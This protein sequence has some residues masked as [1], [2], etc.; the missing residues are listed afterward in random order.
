MKVKSWEKAAPAAA[1][2]RAKTIIFFML[3]PVC[4]FTTL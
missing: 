4:T 3:P 1:R 2:N